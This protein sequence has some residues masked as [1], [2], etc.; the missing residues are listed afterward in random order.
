MTLATMGR[1]QANATYYQSHFTDQAD[2]MTYAMDLTPLIKH[3]DIEIPDY[4]AGFVQKLSKDISKR[5]TSF[6]PD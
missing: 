1:R 6:K 2:M 4:I 3:P 5:L